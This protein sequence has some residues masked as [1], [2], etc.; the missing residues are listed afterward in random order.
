MAQLPRQRLADGTH[1]DRLRALAL[2]TAETAS[3]PGKS[4]A[5]TPDR[6]I[7]TLKQNTG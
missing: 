3:T 5:P 2:Y 7:Q 4:T 1:D 6:S